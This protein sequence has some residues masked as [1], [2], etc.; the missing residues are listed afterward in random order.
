MDK[1]TF[2]LLCRRSG[3]FRCQNIFVVCVTLARK[4]QIVQIYGKFLEYPQTTTKARFVLINLEFNCVSGK[5]EADPD[6]VF[7]LPTQVKGARKKIQDCFQRSHEALRVREN[8]LLSQIDEMFK[9]F[10]NKLSDFIDTMASM[11]TDAIQSKSFSARGKAIDAVV[12]PKM[13]ELRDTRCLIVFQWDDSFFDKIENLGS[14]THVNNKTNPDALAKVHQIVYKSKSPATG[15]SPQP[16]T[17]TTPHSPTHAS[18]N[19]G[20]N[21]PNSDV[22]KGVIK[23]AKRSS[24]YKKH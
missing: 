20:S 5:M 4:Y 11:D 6:L 19:T 21:Q 2:V 9:D 24:L 15:S 10:D 18:F 22:S 14:I 3:R 7:Y 1:S 13:D 16:N 23:T 12:R 8:A 17:P